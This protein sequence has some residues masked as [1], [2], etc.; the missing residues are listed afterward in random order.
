[1]RGLFDKLVS[2]STNNISEKSIYGDKARREG[3]KQGFSGKMPTKL[4][5][6][7]IEK[8]MSVN[9]VELR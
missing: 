9:I 8:F 4:S 5:N 3:K 7:E 1:M 6:E 2:R